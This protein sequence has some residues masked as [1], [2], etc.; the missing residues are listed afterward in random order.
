MWSICEFLKP[1]S[2]FC[3]ESPMWL[4]LKLNILILVQEFH[5]KSLVAVFIWEKEKGQIVDLE[6]GGKGAKM[7]SFSHTYEYAKWA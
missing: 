5:M 4:F 6:Y 2:F 1:F 3:R 7:S